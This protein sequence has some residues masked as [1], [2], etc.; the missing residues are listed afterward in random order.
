MIQQIYKRFL[1]YSWALLV[2][3]LPI[4]SM[5]LIVRVVGSNTVGALSGIFLFLLLVLWFLPH[6]FKGG[7]ISRQFIPLFAFTIAAIISTLFAS[8]SPIPLYKEF[9]SVNN[10][11]TSLITLF[12]GIAFYLIT[13]TWIKDQPGLRKTLRYLNW[14]GLVLL[15]IAGIQGLSWYTLGGYPEWMRDL[16]N[17]YSVGPLFRQRPTGMSYE[18]SWLANQLNML[19]LP[20]WLAATIKGYSSHNWRFKKISIENLL[21]FGGVIILMLTLSRVGMIAFFLMLFYVLGIFGM[22]LFAWG[23]QIFIRNKPINA[24][25]G[26]INRTLSLVLISGLF[27]IVIA[28]ILF[29]AGYGLSLVDRRMAQIFQFS[30]F[31][32]NAFLKYAENLDFGSRIIYWEAGWRVFNKFPIIGVGLGNTGFY[33]PENI[34]SYGW[35]LMEVREFMFRLNILPNLKSIWIRILAESGI[36]GFILFL[37]WLYVLW[38]ASRFLIRQRLPLQESIGL[39]GQFTMIALI[40]EGFSLDSFAMPY[41]WISLGIVTA[42]STWVLSI[43]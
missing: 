31:Q 15:V 43:E 24:N 38:Q 34:P 33:F 22:K 37:S 1:D 19:Y 18:P 5:P 3:L 7:K 26:K 40:A 27:I 8:F 28:M 42:C 36:T 16:H 12:I 30:P 10:E 25:Q 20:Y 2:L 32:E 14:G 29:A 11:I 21:L 6:L 13:S 4:T 39:A 35:K 23:N 41:L 9:S 17:I